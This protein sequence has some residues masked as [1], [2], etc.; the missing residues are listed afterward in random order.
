MSAQTIVGLYGTVIGQNDTIAELS[1]QLEAVMSHTAIL[2]DKRK[3]KLHKPKPWCLTT[4][5][6]GGANVMELVKGL[7]QRTK[8]ERKQERKSKTIK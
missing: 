5:S 2:P 4:T 8:Q 3:K 1:E 7:R 6:R